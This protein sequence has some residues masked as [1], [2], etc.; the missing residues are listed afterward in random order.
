M[1]RRPLLCVCL[2]GIL[3]IWLLQAAGILVAGQAAIERMTL[4]GDRENV[5]VSG[6][7]TGR[8]GKGPEISALRISG[9]FG[10]YD[11]PEKYRLQVLLPE[12]ADTVLGRAE[13][14]DA[15]DEAGKVVLGGA[16][17]ASGNAWLTEIPLGSRVELS[18]T[19]R[20]YSHGENPG[21][22]DAAS[23]YGDLDYIGTLRDPEVLGT[24]E[25]EEH[26]LFWRVRNALAL[27]REACVRRIYRVYP[28]RE[29]SVMADLLMGER[30]GLD[31]E[32][33]SLFRENGIAH[34]LSIS[35]LHISIIGLTIFRLLRKTYL[36]V[37]VCC[38]IPMGILG[39]YVILTGGSIS[40]VRAAG[41]VILML[42]AQAIGR[43]PDPPT[44]LALLAFLLLLRSPAALRSASF[45]LS[46]GAVTGILLIAPTLQVLWERI[47]PKKEKVRFLREDSG[48]PLWEGVRKLAAPLPGALLNTL[49]ISLGLQLATLPATLW[50]YYEVPRYALFLN[51]LVLP[52]MTLLLVAGFLAL[53]P[54]LGIIGTVSYQ[55]LRL[56]EWLCGLWDRL[57]GRSWNP[58]R[59]KPWM[60][61]CYVVIWLLI[62]GLC[63]E[64]GERFAKKFFGRLR[65][66]IRGRLNGN[67]RGSLGGN[68]PERFGGNIRGSL[69]RNTSGRLRGK[70][71]SGTLEKTL[72]P[73]RIA[74][75]AAAALGIVSIALFALPR[76]VPGSVTFL[77]V[78]QGDAIFLVTE[79]REIYLVDGGSTS[80]E[81]VGEYVLKPFLKYMG[82]SRID[83]IF[84]SHPDADHMNGLGE[85]VAGRDTWNLRMDGIYVTPQA[86]EDDSELMEMFLKNA[87]DESF[88]RQIPVHTITA[89]DAWHSGETTL[90]CLHPSADFCGTDPNETSMCLLISLR[91]AGPLVLLTG[92]IQG[93]GEQRLMEALEALP[94]FSTPA[95]EE[96]GA[97]AAPHLI[98]KV[99]HHGSKYSTPEEFLDLI[100]PNLAV[101]SA[102]T[103]SIY[104]HPH[105]ELL[106]RL[107]D[108]GAVILRTDRHG[109]ITITSYN[110]PQILVS[111]P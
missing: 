47:F 85:L 11:Y 100:H 28:A 99:A 29:A 31:R 12:E 96:V 93:A 32:V 86:L 103:R 109:A 59:P 73:G 69:D 17:E 64:E 10:A 36:P 54:G 68:T 48:H 67:I 24:E 61:V 76:T 34:I 101:I 45:L 83:G 77:S 23:Y 80:R 110:S 46:F 88:R 56:M 79:A 102:P 9:D 106:Q 91:D 95:S 6:C 108:F 2:C 22:F 20:P 82:C 18:G 72:R 25:A 89:E 62:A 63:S 111:A 39:L 90:S 30:E 33:K 41:T 1:L 92:D 58:G 13:E 104:G 27:F 53:L 51:L 35:G 65:K 52:F 75:A 71:G 66:M 4:P 94:V 97:S 70:T 21:E 44:S 78:G 19:F 5:T 57:P 7:L 60:V 84:L 105:K 49:R 50:F 87:S 15:N 107:E 40:A 81:Q 3:L 55:I 26:A 43:T 74:Y 42:L 14:K 16:E 8:T 38:V 37:P 98:L